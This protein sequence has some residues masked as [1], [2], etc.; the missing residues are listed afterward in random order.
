MTLLEE[1]FPEASGGIK[2]AVLKRLIRIIIE[3][4]EANI[5][6]VYVV[7]IRV[8]KIYIVSTK[9]INFIN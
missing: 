8:W 1:V 2:V 3:K 9:V 5:N 6:M 7:L 4:W